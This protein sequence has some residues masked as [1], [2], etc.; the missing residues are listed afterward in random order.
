MR[1]YRIFDHREEWVARPG[2]NPLNGEGGL[3]EPGRWHHVGSRLVYASQS[4]SLAVLETLVWVPPHLF[5]ERT[6]LELEVPDEDLEEVGYAQMFRLVHDA[7]DDERERLTRDHGTR[8]L[9]ERRSLGLVVP[10][11][12]MPVENN[13]LLN[14]DHPKMSAVKELRRQVITLDPRLLGSAG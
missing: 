9:R 5:E 8:W 1:V 4:P 12:V 11:A 3:Y 2:A 6:L 13:V 7:P 10:S 14:P